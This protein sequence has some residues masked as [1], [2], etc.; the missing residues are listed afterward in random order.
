MEILLYILILL[1]FGVLIYYPYKYFQ[2]Q[3][4]KEKLVF[5][6]GK[7]ISCRVEKDVDDNDVDYEV[8]FRYKFL[9]DGKEYRGKYYK[10]HEQFPSFDTRVEA[11]KLAKKYKDQD[12]IEVFY[13][14]DDKSYCCLNDEPMQIKELALGIF[15]GLF[16]FSVGILVLLK[17]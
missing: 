17:G 15:A 9:V 3:K 14:P 4:K 6:E 1:G 7:L 10:A 2:T 8:H 13:D 5:T 11:E 16:M 12:K